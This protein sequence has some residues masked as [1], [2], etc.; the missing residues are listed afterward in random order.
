MKKIPKWRK[1]DRNTKPGKDEDWKVYKGIW[2]GTDNCNSIQRDTY[3][4]PSSVLQLTLC[5]AKPGC[6]S[7]VV[8]PSS[9]RLWLPCLVLMVWTC[10][11]A[12]RLWLKPAA[13]HTGRCSLRAAV[14]V[15]TPCH[16]PTSPHPATVPAEVAAGWLAGLGLPR[17]PQW[18]QAALWRSWELS[19]NSFN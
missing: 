16:H 19:A 3:R 2:Y 10:N 14:P 15:C 9:S 6:N 5:I 1:A 12:R 7:T 17:Q 18:L 11:S 13:P 4:R 8:L